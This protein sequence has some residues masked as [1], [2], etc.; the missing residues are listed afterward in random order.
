MLFNLQKIAGFDEVLDK[1][2]GG[3]LHPVPKTPS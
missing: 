1:I 2:A 3:E